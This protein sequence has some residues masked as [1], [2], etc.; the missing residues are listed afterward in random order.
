M[1]T[2]SRALCQ[3]LPNGLR[4]VAVPDP[5]ALIAEIRLALP[6]ARTR[7]DL[8]APMDLLAA[9]VLRGTKSRDRH[10]VLRQAGDLG[11]ELA[12][13]RDSESLLLSA[14]VLNAGFAGTLEL[15]ADVVT[16]PAYQNSEVDAAAETTAFTAAGW[17]SHMQLRRTLL[18]HRFGCHPLSADPATPAELFAVTPDDL[19][20]LHTKAIVPVGAVLLVLSSTE[21]TEVLDRLAELFSSWQ[22]S[23]SSLRLPELDASTIDDSHV[24]LAAEPNASALVATIGPGLP[25]SHPEHPALQLTNLILGG[26]GSSRLSTRIRQK[27]GL[28]YS[29]G[30][31]LEDPGAGAWS[32]V[33]V[34]TALGNGPRVLREVASCMEDL[35]DQGPTQQEVE[36]ARQFATGFATIGLSTRAEMASAATGF[37]LRGLPPDWLCSY[38][39]RVESITVAEVAAAAR[40][41]APGSH[42]FGVCDVREN[43]AAVEEQ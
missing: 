28:A 15:L 43:P 7:A 18:R 12:S 3:T 9:C 17:G 32:S 4:V 31:S 10:A 38:F 19:H 36:A 39:D 41:W 34:A 29:V 20:L 22:G 27:L 30:S 8:T 21:P 40:H 37:I 13:S 33:T 23:A 16:R 24:W 14:S 11:A 6:F 5:S 2:L 42:S 26:T 1:K 35:A 25:V